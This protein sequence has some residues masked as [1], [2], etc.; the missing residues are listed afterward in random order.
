MRIARRPRFFADNA[1]AFVAVAVCA[2]ALSTGWGLFSLRL[3]DRGE[4]AQSAAADVARIW[5]GPLQQPQPQV[6]WR[7]ADAATVELE[8]GELARTDVQVDLDVDY[9]RRGITEYPGYEARVT[10][11]YEFPNPSSDAAFVAFTVGLPVERSALM[12]RDL[13]LLVDGKEDAAHTEYSPEGIAWRG[14]VDGGHVA[15]FGLA[16]RARGLERFGYRFAPNDKLDGKGVTARPVSAFKLRMAI[17]GAK[18]ELDL[19]V[20]AMAPTS[21]VQGPDGARVYSWDVER[22]LT[23]FDVGVVLPDRR[24]AASA[25]GRLIRNAP[26]FYLLYAA[27]LLFALSSV[28]ARPRALHVAG[29][30]AAYFLYFP[31]AAYLSAYLPWPIA[32]TLAL[33]G[34]SALAVGHAARF[35]G[36]RAGA[37]VALAQLFFLATPAVAYLLPAHTGLIL[38]VAGFVALTVALQFVGK[39]AQRLGDDE[40]R[41]AAPPQAPTVGAQA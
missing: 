2:A 7:R 36:G 28:R 38:V 11:S 41:G 16:Y 26:W 19:P 27:S 37:Q 17:R 29:L 31:L 1:P 32:A 13:A 15:R 3:T 35:V 14:R 6:R 39:M 40:E 23:S 18:G 20:G 21:T 9:R 22:L 5:G 8:T 24:E 12:L 34:L 30:S 33:A 25:I 10:A 4:R